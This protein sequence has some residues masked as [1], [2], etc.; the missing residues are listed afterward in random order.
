MRGLYLSI[1]G[2]SLLLLTTYVTSIA[3]SKPIPSSPKLLDLGKKVYNR[4]CGD[5]CSKEQER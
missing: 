2:L 1:A 3:E 5:I 4:Q